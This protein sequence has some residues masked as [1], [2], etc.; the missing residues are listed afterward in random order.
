[1]HATPASVPSF[2][3]LPIEEGNHIIRVLYF[4]K[5]PPQALRAE[6]V[7]TERLLAAIREVDDAK[8]QWMETRQVLHVPC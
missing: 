7:E 6:E 4:E 1:M 2:L 5:L 3:F 8:R